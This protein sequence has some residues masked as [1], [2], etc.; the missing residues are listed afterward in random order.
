MAKLRKLL[1]SELDFIQNLQNS[2]IRD[3]IISNPSNHD[4]RIIRNLCSNVCKGNFKFNKPQREKLI[5]HAK[6]IRTLG[7]PSKKA[8]KKYIG[9]SGE[10]LGVLAPL[11][12]EL[13]KIVAQ[14]MLKK[15]VPV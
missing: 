6:I 3:R 13:I 11:I 2:H 9:Q 8:V 4:V 14:K 1:R 5:P 7:D 15:L 10:A 12:T